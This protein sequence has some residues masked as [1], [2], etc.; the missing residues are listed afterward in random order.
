MLRF[1]AVSKHFGQLRAVWNVTLAFAPGLIYSVIG[2][3]GAGKSTLV[4][5]AAGSYSVSSGSITLD[6]TELSRLPKHR[7]FA[8]G[9]ARTYQNIR[10]FDNMSVRENVEVVLYR[11][12]IGSVLGELLIPRVRRRLREERVARAR[13]ALDDVGMLRHEEALAGALPYGLQK[14]LE[15]ARVLAGRPRALLLDEPA[16]GLNE[17]ESADMRDLLLRLRSEHRILLVIEH[18]MELVM[19]ISDQ[20][21]VMF[22]GELLYSGTPEAVR[23][24]DAVQEA[25]LGRSDDLTDLH[26]AFA[27]RRRVRGLRQGEGAG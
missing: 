6:R 12:Q 1:D 26:D 14:K 22:H 19:S 2:P 5:M 21:Y 24:S 9:L 7:I 23:G 25:Y 20:I 15:I 13:A 17:A 8:A 18:D 27:A 11:E 16:A 3:N 4:N 10:L